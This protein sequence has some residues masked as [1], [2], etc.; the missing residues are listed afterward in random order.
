MRF[1]RLSSFSFSKLT[2]QYYIV[3]ALL[4]YN[5]SCKRELFAL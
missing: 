2:T 1:P 5:M 4:F 3:Y